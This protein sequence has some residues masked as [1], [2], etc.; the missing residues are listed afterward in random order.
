MKPGIIGVAIFVIAVL[1][2]A[3][4]ALFGMFG[5]RGSA[6]ATVPAAQSLTTL[7][8]YLGGEKESFMADAEVRSILAGDPYHLDPQLKKGVNRHGAR[9][10]SERRRLSLALRRRGRADLRRPTR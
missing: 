1:V 7:T 10:V 6:P 4:Y 2:V 3:G 5:T 9:S 8:G